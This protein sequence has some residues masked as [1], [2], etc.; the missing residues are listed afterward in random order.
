VRRSWKN[1]VVDRLSFDVAGRSIL[2]D[3]VFEGGSAIVV[4]RGDEKWFN[5]IITQTPVY[6]SAKLETHRYEASGAWWFLEN[7]IYQQAWKVPI[8]SD[9]PD[10]QLTTIYKGHIILCQGTSG[11]RVTIGDQ[12]ADIINYANACGA[13][14]CLGEISIE[15]HIPFDECKD[16]SCADAIRR[17]LRWVP[18]TVCFI[19]YS[20]DVP[21]ISF[22]RR[23]QLT[24]TTIDILDSKVEQFS[25]QPRY[26]LC[27]P[28]VV[29][30]FETS[31]SLNGKT[32]KTVS[33]QKYPTD[34]T[35]MEF[36]SLVL[37]INLE[38]AKSTCI[39]Q[40]ITSAP[41]EISSLLWWKQH[42]PW[43]NKFDDVSVANATRTGTLPYE[44]IDGAVANWMAKDA[45]DDVIRANVSYRSD[46]MA[47]VD[48]EI[49]VK[50]RATDAATGNY[51]KLVSLLTAEAV[52]NNLA[53]DIFESVGVLQYDG[54]VTLVD[55]E[56]GIKYEQFLINFDF[57]RV[58]W[59]SINAVVQEVEDN[60]DSGKIYVK[61]GPAKHLGAAD[62][63]ELTRSGRLLY[64]SRNY[65]ERETA[66]AIGNGVVDQGVYSRVENTSTGD[67][68]YNM[69]KFVDSENPNS[70]VK[71]DASDLPQ[72]LTVSLREE[73]VCESGVLKKRFSLASE[74]FV[75]T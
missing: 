71:I 48:Q 67:C 2:D 1:Q 42:V 21:E 66:E 11:E 32:W 41:I 5:G 56:V 23:T 19:D 27:V 20:K 40:K 37:T 18:D 58:E 44:L 46:D 29:L 3:P 74:P 30:K 75:N 60:L 35:G 62:L 50:I 57:G 13:N 64:E 8:D 22:R 72:S 52:P 65:G 68:K 9:D 55:R 43:L 73:D 31:N 61:F 51:K 14:L 24:A 39:T 45:E 54:S 34:S 59:G 10:S 7:L 33:V 53:Q 26:D 38:G 36:K 70:T 49:A 16:L 28:S 63:T 69:L 47:V 17:L 6:G 4:F 25:M 15:V 12:I